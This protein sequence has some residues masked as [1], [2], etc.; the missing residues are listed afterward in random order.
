MRIW[1]KFI[2]GASGLVICGPVGALFGAV[3]GHAV[4]KM[5]GGGP[6]TGGEARQMTFTGAVIILS[7]KMAKADGRVTQA[8]IDAFKN[9]FEIPSDKGKNVGGLLDDARMD[10]AGFE[11]YA[12]HVAH[13]FAHEPA[14]LEELLGELI[15]IAK[16]DGAVNTAELRFLRQVAA[17]FGFDQQRF[18]RIRAAH[19]ECEE[20]D[21]YQVLGLSRDTSDADIKMI[22][23]ELIRKNHQDNLMAQGLPQEFIVVANQKMAAINA[24]YDRVR[25]QRGL[26]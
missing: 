18:E 5:R 6:D 26:T 20:A 12:K 14:V 15:R 11:P 2:G 4:D 1:G 13:K 22:Y 7:A 9:I 10:A 23:R 19:V 17:I 24:A 3:A 21:P 8:E 25:K 16:A